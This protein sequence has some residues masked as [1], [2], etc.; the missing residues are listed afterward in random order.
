M[1]KLLK[2]LALSAKV[3]AF[4][5]ALGAVIVG[6]CGPGEDP[7]SKSSV[8]R[9]IVQ[10][11]LPTVNPALAFDSTSN[12][13]VSLSDHQSLSDSFAKPCNSSDPVWSKGFA[14]V[15]VRIGPTPAQLKDC[16]EGDAIPNGLPS[17]I[18]GTGP[19][20]SPTVAR[21]TNAWVIL[22]TATKVDSS[23][24]CIGAASGAVPQGPFP[25]HSIQAVVCPASASVSDP[26]L[27]FDLQTNQWFLLWT[28]DVGTA[29]SRLMI[30]A[31]DP[32]AVTLMPGS[33]PR[34]LLRS[35]DPNVR[36]AEIPALDGGAPRRRVESPSMVRSGTGELWLLFSANDAK[37]NNYA[38]AWA[39]CG[40]GSPTT[41]TTCTLPNASLPNS[42][43]RPWWGDM[44]RTASVA[45]VNAAPFINW[46]ALPGFG[47][48]SLAV[49]SPTSATPQ[50]IYAVNQ[51]RFGAAPGE[52]V[53][54]FDDA[55]PKP[56]LF[57]ADPVNW[58]GAANTFGD[59]RFVPPDGGAPYYPT[60]S[61]GLT[62]P[63]GQTVSSRGVSG[64]AWSAPRVSGLFNEVSTDGTLF[65]SGLGSS[66]NVAPAADVTLLGAFDQK[67]NQ[68]LNIPILTSTGASSIPGRTS[69]F[70]SFVNPNIPE[71]MNAGGFIAD[72]QA[73]DN[74]A[75]AFVNSA[76][77]PAAYWGLPG[78]SPPADTNAGVW[79]TF[80]IATKVNDQWQ[81]LRQ[82]Q[83]TGADLRNLAGSDLTLA[84]QICPES[85]DV[86]PAGES[87]CQCFNEI[88]MM[89]RSKD[90]VITQYLSNDGGL[91]ALHYEIIPG[92]N[93]AAYAIKW[94]GSFKYPR[95]VKNGLNK[96]IVADIKEI[97][98]DP[99]SLPD[100]E[101]FVIDFDLS[102]VDFSQPPPPNVIQEFS[103]HPNATDL[104]QRITP[105]SAPIL[106]YGNA[107][108]DKDGNLWAYGLA[109]YAVYAKG[110]NG[111]KIS[112]S[113]CGF[114]PNNMTFDYLTGDDWGKRCAPDYVIRE[115]ELLYWF[116]RDIFKPQ[117]PPKYWPGITEF[118]H[119]PTDSI[120]VGMNIGDLNPDV[121]QLVPVRYSGSG[122]AMKFE[123]GNVTDTGLGFF[124][125]LE[126]KA[127][128][129]GS[130]DKLGRMWFI[131]S[132]SNGSGFAT[133]WVAS[134]DIAQLFDPPAVV[135]S[136]VQNT[137]V[138]IQAE[139]I[140][141]SSMKTCT[142]TNSCAIDANG[143]V[144]VDPVVLVQTS[145][146]QDPDAKAGTGDG[147]VLVTDKGV[148]P[149]G[150]NLGHK[151]GRADYKVFI[152]QTGNYKVSYFA[153]AS[154]TTGGDIVLVVDP[155]TNPSTPITTTV[156]TTSWTTLSN[157]TAFQ[158]S[159]G[160]HTIAL[161][162]PASTS[163]AQWHLD[164]FTL[165]RQ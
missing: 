19:I 14:N 101:R 62:T 85:Q 129:P 56:A 93:P 44:N 75:I 23:Q 165:T 116:H 78:G 20:S 136:A 36:F 108:Y 149:D 50:P 163:T 31:L 26:Q 82:N 77:F 71:P 132:H 22:Y 158:L 99:S 70:W 84:R 157:P 42:Q 91:A 16:W 49:K 6:A 79:P 152:P 7:P 118:S 105:T 45:G 103:Y 106:G 34:E 58:Y 120:M 3:G 133:N 110:P 135:L 66:L 24:T 61:A 107:R 115:P 40:T 18:W 146:R 1:T 12:V 161:T 41:G 55:G 139:N 109:G 155:D 113:A 145:S 97:Q 80:G 15:P 151:A 27:Y 123:I 137:A 29:D 51:M 28:E 92:S 2:A 138:R 64:F 53:F 142:Q 39:A 100:D 4:G 127:L 128:R 32:S 57:E 13:W 9:L 114:E 89:P 126:G 88:A 47:G 143:S 94:M 60:S 8:E 73:L 98:V 147:T 102:F 72:I 43:F 86:L 160:L 87:D 162:P 67:T 104:G 74:N 154:G 144:I 156:T 117:D 122:A 148:L 95:T 48:M 46:P 83:W 111:R 90:L 76:G 164:Y 54:R 33:S 112:T 159:A 124:A 59:P 25:F 52:L 37:S 30:Q 141:A 65:T 130:F 131:V 125:P 21:L 96:T 68:W 10:G 69:A 121:G 17:G 35:N 150:S 5:T 140:A 11:S 81:V 134:N 119:H 63:S 38:T 153:K